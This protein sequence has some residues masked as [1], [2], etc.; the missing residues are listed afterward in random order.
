MCNQELMSFT[1]SN[2]AICHVNASIHDSIGIKHCVKSDPV[3][4]SCAWVLTVTCGLITLVRLWCNILCQFTELKDLTRGPEGLYHSPGIFKVN[5]Q[6]NVRV[7][8]MYLSPQRQ[9][10]YIDTGK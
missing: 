2:L 10:K 5:Q 9:A 6:Y 1:S 8:V 4:C 3:V 7:S